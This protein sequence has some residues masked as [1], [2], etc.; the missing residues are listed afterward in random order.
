MPAFNRRLLSLLGSIAVV[1]LSAREAAAN[2]PPYFVYALRQENGGANQIYGFQIGVF[3]AL[4][5]LPGFPVASGGTGSA[6]TASEQIAYGNGRLYVINDGSDTLSAFAVNRA[7]GAL[8]SLPFSPIALGIGSWACVA[9]HPSGSPVV[10]GRAMG[11]LRSFAVT[12]TTA[13][14]S[15]FVGTGEAPFSCAFSR[16]GNFVYTGGALN[17]KIGGYSVAQATGVL[18]PLPGSPFDAGIS[19]PVAYATDSAG[20]LFTADVLNDQAQVFTTTG[21]VPTG[22]SNNPFHPHVFGVHG[23]LHPAGF[24]ILA[25]RSGKVGVLQIAGGGAGT[26]LTAVSGSPFNTGGTFSDALALAHDGLNLVVA[27]GT[28]RNLTVFRV[29]SNTGALQLLGV[30]A[31]DTL[32]ATGLLTGVAYAPPPIAGDF[33]ADRQGDV[34]WRNKVTG[35]NVA[36]FMDGASVDGAG[37]LPSIPN[38]NWEVKGVGDFDATSNAD[39]IWRNKSSGENI[40]W[41][42]NGTGVASATFL[43]TIADTN[44]E[45]KGVGDFDADGRADVIWRNKVSGENIVWLMDGVSVALSA[46]LPTIA[47]TNWDMVGVGDFDGDGKADVIWRNKATG[48]NIAWLMN[49]ASVIFSAFLPPIADTNWEI[50]GVGDLNSDAEADVMWRNK[51]TGQNIAWLMNGPTVASSAFLPTIADTNW[52][53]KSMRDLDGDA[54]VDIVWRKKSTGQNLAWLMSGFLIKVSAFLPTVANLDWEIVSR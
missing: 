40:V 3:G 31:P 50:K 7:T 36:W 35:Q 26:T 44:Y 12:A 32:G 54:R 47:D 17:S 53:I 30:Q 51:V 48:D 27:N 25:S 28:S 18:T 43:P 2:P 14:S 19:A 5:P 1:L 33:N 11:G 39:V 22:V 41:L 10:V 16:D 6:G 49:G 46:L 15:S 37:V 45:I 24:Y 21:G 9:A 8:T 38:T 20:R 29:D 34:L 4:T 52:E 13:T 42:I 23:V